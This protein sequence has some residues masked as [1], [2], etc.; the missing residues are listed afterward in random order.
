M[1]KIYKIP[2]INGD[3]FHLDF[4]QKFEKTFPKFSIVR[5][6]VKKIIIEYVSE[7]SK[8]DVV[9]L[10]LNNNIYISPTLRN[11]EY[12]KEG[13]LHEIG[14]IL[15]SRSEINDNEKIKDE[16]FLKRKLVLQELMRDYKVPQRIQDLFKN[17]EE[18]SIELDKYLNE[19]IGYN[20][21]EQYID[22]Y[23]LDPYAISSFD[24][25]LAI[26]FQM[27]FSEYRDA[28]KNTNPILYQNIETLLDKF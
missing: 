20:R 1:D 23:F 21:M 7:M 8:K 25:Y 3:E 27:Y 12:L 6:Y 24:E 19:K 26:G 17:L 10:Y 16:F 5:N 14:H 2:I 22:G 28:L 11:F 18:F 15:L 9:M 13:F 4:F